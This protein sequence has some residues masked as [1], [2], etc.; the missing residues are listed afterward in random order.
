MNTAELCWL[1]FLGVIVLVAVISIIAMIPEM[2]RYMKI[3]SM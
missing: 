1:V 2:V 3:R